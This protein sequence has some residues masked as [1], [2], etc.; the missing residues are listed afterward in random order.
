LSL[1]A[2]ALSPIT[3]I[4]LLLRITPELRS[5]LDPLPNRT[6]LAS[7]PVVLMLLESFSVIVPLS[8]SM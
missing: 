8:P 6:A 2:A 1:L 5:V 3:A 7:G 4:S